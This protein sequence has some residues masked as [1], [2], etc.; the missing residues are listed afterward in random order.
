MR[1]AFSFACLMGASAPALAQDSA[2]PA[3]EKWRPKDGLYAEPGADLND[4]CMDH[5]EVVVELAD[6]SISGNEWKCKIIKLADIAQGT[7]RLDA[8]CTELEEKPYKT[9]FLLKKIDDK[10]ILYRTYSNG[11]FKAPAEPMSYCPENGQRRYTEAKARDR[12]EAEQKAAE[13]RSKPKN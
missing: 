13:E 9:I 12:A 10:T 7:V 1:S 11:K 4:R 3:T 5:T 8:T 2:R 6:K